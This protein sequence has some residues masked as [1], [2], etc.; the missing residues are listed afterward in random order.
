MA[1]P[2]D[3]SPLLIMTGCY[4]RPGGDVKK[5]SSRSLDQHMAKL[6]QKVEDDPADPRHILTVHG[7]GYRF[8]S[9]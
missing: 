1:A 5:S 9:K 2:C 7:V 6:R 4:R 8:R 3:E